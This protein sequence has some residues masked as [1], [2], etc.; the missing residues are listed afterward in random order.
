MPL[1]HDSAKCCVIF[2]G[3]CYVTSF[4][5]THFPVYA[6]SVFIMEYAHDYGLLRLSPK[7]RQRLQV[8]V[9]LII[10][11]P[12]KDPCFG[13]PLSSFILEHIVGYDDLLLTA[14]KHVAE[15]DGS[16]GYLR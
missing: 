9:T 7:T 1:S 2:L 6:D 10:L 15:N 8:P 16:K 14:V 4:N 13:G 12:Q 5:D 3:Q 11:D